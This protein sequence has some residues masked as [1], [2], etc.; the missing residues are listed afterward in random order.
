MF[1][2]ACGDVPRRSAASRTK[3]SASESSEALLCGRDGCSRTSRTPS[4][5]AMSAE[6]SG[7]TWTP[8]NPPRF[9]PWPEWSRATISCHTSSGWSRRESAWSA[10][11]RVTDGW[12]SNQ[13]RLPSTYRWVARWLSRSTAEPKFPTVSPGMAALSH[14]RCR[15]MPRWAVRSVGADPM[16]IDRARRRVIRRAPSVGRSASIRTGVD[17]SPSMSR[18]TI[19]FH[20][21]GRYCVISLLTRA[22]SSGTVPGRMSGAASSL[23]HRACTTVLTRRRTPRVPWNRS[24]VD[25]SS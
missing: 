8:T 22:T 17:P 6:D 11:V 3:R 14:T 2:F 10:A 23:V 18:S 25:Q 24:S 9:R 7:A 13:Y 12:V 20:R 21:S 15:S 16:K 5:S 19:G 1:R 4:V